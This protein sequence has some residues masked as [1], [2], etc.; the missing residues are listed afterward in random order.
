MEQRTFN[1]LDQQFEPAHVLT[2]YTRT[3]IRKGTESLPRLLFPFGAA[4]V[5]PAASTE[6]GGGVPLE[7]QLKVTR[8]GRS[9][10]HCFNAIW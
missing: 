1:P 5:F 7:S 2:G 9:A 3:I 6:V 4:T 8:A 10:G